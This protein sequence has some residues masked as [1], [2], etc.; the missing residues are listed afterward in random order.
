MRCSRWPSNCSPTHRCRRGH[1]RGD[2]AR[3]R[4]RRRR[5][6]HVRRPGARHR[7]HRQAPTSTS[8]R[9]ERLHALKT[10]ALL[11]AVGAPGC[12][13]APASTRRRCTR[14]DAFADALGLA[15]QIRD[16]LL[17]IEGDSATLG[18]TAGKD[19]AQAKATFP[20]LL[21]VDASR[22]RLHALAGRDA[23]RAGSRSAR[24]P[25]R[26]RR[27]HDRRSTRR[28]TE[29]PL[30]PA[31]RRHRCSRQCR[32]RGRGTH[33]TV[34]LALQRRAGLGSKPLLASSAHAFIDRWGRLSAATERPYARL[35]LRLRFAFYPLL[36]IWRAV[37]G[38]RWDWH[39][40]SQPRF[41]RRRD[42]RP[43]DPA[44]ADGA[45]AFGPRGR[46]RD[47]R[48]LDR[49]SA[50][51]EGGWPWSRQRMRTCWTRSIAP[52]CARSATT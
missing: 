14:L 40:R 1:A 6:R 12:D 3:T 48:L 5:A 41:G 24:A 34:K 39:A 28:T 11:R 25:T 36:A 46:R 47:R 49:H 45:D 51:G 43:G 20:A 23:R 32:S 13:R 9:C 22:A 50:L 35:A 33:A 26:S 52:A 38:W 8:T 27:W 10:G 44:A 29:P 31:R 17:D 42:L 19:V 7:R 2:A 4:R 30:T 21:G 16:D 37:G 18:K 15:F